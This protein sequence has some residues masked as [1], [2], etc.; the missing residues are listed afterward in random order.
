MFLCISCG[1]R[2][3]FWCQ[4]IQDIRFS[5]LTLLEHEK[6]IVPW[7]AKQGAVFVRSI[8]ESFP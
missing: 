3:E 4:G 6:K 7:S 1:C 8:N 2:D 5:E